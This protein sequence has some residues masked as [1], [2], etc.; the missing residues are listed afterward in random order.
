[1]CIRDRSWD[2]SDANIS[3]EGSYLVATSG[4]NG[5]V[6]VARRGK[7]KGSKQKLKASSTQTPYG[8][9]TSVTVDKETQI[10]P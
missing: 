5:N 10:S 7:L 9:K 2:Y 3:Y 4:S 6:V 1:M 8:N